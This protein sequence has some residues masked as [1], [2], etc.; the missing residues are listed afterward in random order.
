MAD[1][2]LPEDEA[3]PALGHDHLRAWDEVLDDATYYEIL[4]VLEIADPDAI[5]RAFHDFSLA[6]HPDAQP[7][8]DEDARAIALRIFRRGVEAYRAL[9][10]PEQ[11]SAYD[12]ALAKGEVRLGEGP[13]TRVEDRGPGAAR[14][15]DELCRS[16]G[17]KLYAKR[18]ED[19]ITAGDLRGATHELYRAL[20]AEDGDNPELAERIAA[21]TA[22]SRLSGYPGNEP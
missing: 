19:F 21:L 3:P 10:A 8:G 16:P 14:S 11:R 20:R 18:A 1:D 17:A 5:R 4:G 9:S 12:L 2:T 6:F 13:S 22:L 7:K 15:L